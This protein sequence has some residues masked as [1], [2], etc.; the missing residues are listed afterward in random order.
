MFLCYCTYFVLSF[1]LYNEGYLT[2]IISSRRMPNLP[3]KYTPGSM[4][5]TSFFRRRP[6]LLSWSTTPSWM[7][8]PTPCPTECVQKRCVPL[9]RGHCMVLRLSLPLCR[10]RVL[11]LEPSELIALAASACL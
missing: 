6:L 3:G 2:I 7:S 5:T 9:Y 4:V 8:N 10:Q 1:S 11:P